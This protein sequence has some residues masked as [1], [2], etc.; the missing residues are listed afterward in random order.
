MI[1]VYVQLSPINLTGVHS[2]VI[3][4]SCAI[5][6]TTDVKSVSSVIVLMFVAIGTTA[7]LVHASTCVI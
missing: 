5:C 1:N 4:S 7:P 3:A 2:I 6:A